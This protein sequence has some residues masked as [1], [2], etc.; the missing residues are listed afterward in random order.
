MFNGKFKNEEIREKG[1]IALGLFKI[2]GNLV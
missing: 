1:R 2:S